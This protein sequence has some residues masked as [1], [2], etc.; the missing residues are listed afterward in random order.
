MELLLDLFSSSVCHGLFSM[1]K[2]HQLEFKKISGL[3]AHLD[4]KSHFV[5]NNLT[6][7]PKAQW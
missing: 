4:H 5:F 1:C 7:K 6:K 3:F 2:M